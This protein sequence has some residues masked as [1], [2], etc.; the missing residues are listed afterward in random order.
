MLHGYMNADNT[1][2]VKARSDTSNYQKERIK[3]D[4]TNERWTRVKNN[5]TVCCIEIKNI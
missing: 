3:S 1:K 5:E 4:W 2:E